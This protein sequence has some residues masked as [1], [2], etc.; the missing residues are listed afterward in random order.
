M[1]LKTFTTVGQ[2]LFLRNP[3]LKFCIILNMFYSATRRA[4]QR[5]DLHTFKNTRML[6]RTFSDGYVKDNKYF[7]FLKGNKYLFFIKVNA[8]NVIFKLNYL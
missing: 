1:E 8:T 7:C 4:Q 2:N 6:L 5:S 3:N